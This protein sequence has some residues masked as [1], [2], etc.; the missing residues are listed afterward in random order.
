MTKT[1]L[2]GAMMFLLVACGGDPTDGTD[3][4]GEQARAGNGTPSSESESASAQIGR[5]H[6]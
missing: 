3:G 2:G 4:A 1:I 5:A 6:V